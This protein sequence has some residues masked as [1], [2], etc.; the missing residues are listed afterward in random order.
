VRP[1]VIKNESARV[2]TKSKKV[3]QFMLAVFSKSDA[4]R[5]KVPFNKNEV[6]ALQVQFACQFGLIDVTMYLRSPLGS[7]L[8]SFRLNYEW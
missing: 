1:N 6:I 4:L 8:Y 2:V 3:N 7:P 5:T